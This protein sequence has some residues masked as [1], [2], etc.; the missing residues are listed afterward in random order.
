MSY[1]LFLG[2]NLPTESLPADPFVGPCYIVRKYPAGG[3]VFQFPPV[4]R[5]CET[6]D[7]E[8]ERFIKE[9]YD[10]VSGLHKEDIPHNIFITRGTPLHSSMSRKRLVIRLYVWTRE[11]FH[12]AKA[13]NSAF[14]AALCE[15]SGHLPVF[16]KEGFD[17]LTEAQ[18]SKILEDV[19]Q[20]MFYKA[21]PVAERS[22]AGL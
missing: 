21:K 1:F 5:K 16:T 11:F 3:F 8:L 6:L 10:F 19:S 15:L 22:F 4:V 14:N 18:V 9:I 2:Y 13:A 12:G 20:E 17:T 7:D